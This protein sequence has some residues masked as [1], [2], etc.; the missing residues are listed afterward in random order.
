MANA[1][2]DT[3]SE[4]GSL[5]DRG[6]FGQ[7]SGLSTLFFVELWERFSY[8]GM[9]AILAY[10]LYFAI[11]DGGLGMEK[12]TAQAVV[13]IYGSSVYLL[14]VVGGFL[15]DRVM[16]AW[17]AT[18][19][20]GIVIM[21]GHISLAVPA[22]VMSWVGIALVAIGTGLLKPNISTMVGGLYDRGD[23]RRD[24]GFS[25][26]YMSV[27]I[28]AFFS[29]LVIA[30]IRSRWGFHAGFSV[31]AFGMAIAVV[32]F[33]LHA[34]RLRGAGSQVP[35][36]LQPGEGRK[37][38]L[39]TVAAI[40][41]FAAVFFVAAAWRGD[42]EGVAR[43]VDAVS[44]FAFGAPIAYF[45]M[46]FRSPRVT[47]TEKSHL[48]A[49]VPLW[50]GAVLFWM[51]FE[52]AS[53]KMATFAEERTS[54]SFLGMSFYAEWFQSV[55]PLAII[56]L[57]PVFAMLWQRRAGRFPSLPMKFATG[58][59]LIGVSAFML[60]WMFSTFDAAHRSPVIL[61]MACFVLQ[62]V[63]ELC[64]SPVGL[65]AT[66]LLA[67][68]AFASQAMA[69]WF[70]SSAAGQALSAQL[71]TMTKDLPDSQ[72]YLING[73]ITAVVAVALFAMVPWVRSKMMDVEE[74]QR[75]GHDKQVAQSGH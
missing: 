74:A 52:Q 4:L 22:A 32:L 11:V 3:R 38:A 40:A 16:G 51:I 60:S 1:T 29:P 61:L 48:W 15:A 49:Y 66:T 34:G 72:Y 33:V 20:G 2:T 23:P 42:G 8:Y 37:V 44:V 57:A 70:L 69:L 35:N 18:L 45:V 47:T 26:F 25:L 30:P 56:V 7:P 5:A 31:A 6:F 68:A 65:S 14:G 59:T 73:V 71:I 50:V 64:L 19:Y 53:G 41:L 28:G 62:T 36:P 21:C 63:G 46:M 43:F 27:N 9:R 10:Y 54:D 13:A 58:V 55:N 17:R 39:W 24:G 75:S 12:P 67:P